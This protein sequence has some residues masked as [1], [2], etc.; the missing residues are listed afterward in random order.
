MVPSTNQADRKTMV[1][2][3]AAAQE[4]KEDTLWTGVASTPDFRLLLRRKAKFVV[5]AT[6]IFVTYYF[7]LP[8]SVGYFP[9]LMN[10]KVLGPVNVAYL[11]ALSQFFMAWT[12]AFLYLW[13]A[14]RFD[15]MGKLVVRRVNDSGDQ[16]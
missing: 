16:G 6:I 13:V 3:A 5:P 15:E 7:L 8:L 9:E 2:G 14:Q 11:Y 4:R 1:V 10:K 12:I